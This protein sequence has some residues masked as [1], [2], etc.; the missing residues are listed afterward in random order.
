MAFEM[1]G[2]YMARGNREAIPAQTFVLDSSSDAADLPVAPVGSVAYT[3]DL[4][5]IYV[6]SPSGTWTEA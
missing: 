3:A 2:T 1:Q 4:A 5:H 6:Y